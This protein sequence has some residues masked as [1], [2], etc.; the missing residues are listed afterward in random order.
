[1][2]DI[3][4]ARLVGPRTGGGVGGGENVGGRFRVAGKGQGGL[5]SAC[6]LGSER[7]MMKEGMNE[8]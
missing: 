7:K 6:V 8:R 5:A 3:G 4:L 1:M 2:R